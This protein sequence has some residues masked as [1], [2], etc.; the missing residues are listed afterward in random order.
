MSKRSAVSA[1]A[2][3]TACMLRSDQPLRGQTELNAAALDMIVKSRME[4]DAM[5]VDWQNLVTAKVLQLEKESGKKLCNG[6]SLYNRISLDLCRSVGDHEE[7]LIKCFDAIRVDAAADPTM[8][9]PWLQ[10][11][12]YG[13]RC[14]RVMKDYLTEWIASDEKALEQ[15]KPIEGVVIVIDE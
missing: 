9:L 10:C 5:T 1:I 8:V 2:G 11:M 15:A 4:I 3:N 13:V 7:L 6:N 12:P 14:C